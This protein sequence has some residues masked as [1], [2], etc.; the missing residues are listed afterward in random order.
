MSATDCYLP[1]DDLLS[2]F[3]TAI[4]IFWAYQAENPFVVERKQASAT[5]KVQDLMKVVIKKLFSGY[6]NLPRLSFLGV[7]QEEG[8]D[9]HLLKPSDIVEAIECEL[10]KSIHF[11]Q[12][13]S[14]LS[15]VKDCQPSTDYIT[16]CEN[17]NQ[18]LVKFFSDGNVT[19]KEVI[20]SLASIMQIIN[21]KPLF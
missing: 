13:S 8:E 2:F 16:T 17:F 5:A 20:F 21:F 19:I 9:E 14:T 18:S 15:L 7:E 4:T 10:T 12:F 6:D 11:F 3:S 1:K